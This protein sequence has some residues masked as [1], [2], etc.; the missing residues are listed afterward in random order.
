MKNERDVEFTPDTTA[1]GQGVD[2]VPSPTLSGGSA[3][4]GTGSDG[5]GTME[6]L[7]ARAGEGLDQAKHLVGQAQE[8]ATDQVRS[9]LDSQKHRAA[10]SLSSVAQTLRS[11]GQQMNGQEGISRYLT[12]A[13]DEVE[14]LA[15]YL[16]DRDVGEL[17]GQVEDF[18]RRQPVAFLGGAFTLGV[19]GARFLKSSRSNLHHHY[20]DADLARRDE[21]LTSRV[22]DP[23]RDAV[24]RPEAPGYAPPSERASSDYKAAGP[25]RDF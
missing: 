4:H 7:K 25:R 19:L 8:R 2:F 6:G 11:S 1:A 3:G 17:L 12:R 18:A 14:N 21:M 16:E 10:D 15:H 24:G 9:R 23:E 13:A 22:R 20:S 5:A